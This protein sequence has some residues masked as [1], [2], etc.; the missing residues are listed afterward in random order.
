LRSELSRQTAILA[1]RYLDVMLGD[2]GALVLVVVQAPLIGA[3]VAGVW[4]N[5]TAD[6]LTLYFVLSLSAFFLGAINSAREIVKERQLFLRERM[7]NLK[8]GAYLASKY[9]VQ[10]IFAVL[11]AVMLA[12]VVR[13]FVPI[14]VNVM[15]VAAVLALVA[16]TGTA[17]GL[18][19]SSAV[20][21]ADKAVAAVPLVVIPQIL[22]SDFVIGEG[23]LSNWTGWAESLM[24]V[25]WSYTLLKSLRATHVEW[26]TVLGSSVVLAVMIGVCFLLSLV[27]LASQEYG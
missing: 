19:I 6:T 4:S 20:S 7:Y 17:V 15:L 23:K 3:L 27:L 8:V 26:T 25:R 9:R 1:E 5:L 16:L 10:A 14:Q 24:P 2:P 11:Q 18:L 12:G 21:S 13:F 22:F